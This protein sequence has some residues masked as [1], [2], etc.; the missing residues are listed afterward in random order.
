MSPLKFPPRRLLRLFT[1]RTDAN[2]PICSAQTFLFMHTCYNTWDFLYNGELP[3]SVIVISSLKLVYLIDHK[4]SLQA[5][6]KVSSLLLLSMIC[7][8]KKITKK[9]MLAC[10]YQASNRLSSAQKIHL[11]PT[12]TMKKIYIIQ[13]P[14]KQPDMFFLDIMQSVWYTKSQSQS[15]WGWS[16][17]HLHLHKHL[18]PKLLYSWK[19][20]RF[21][22]FFLFRTMSSQERK[23]CE[24]EMQHKQNLKY[25][26][27]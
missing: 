11:D 15:W 1:D 5:Q 21:F 8:Q 25:L 18:K 23:Q 20:K 3:V 22:F 7:F 27:V 13:E 2:K 24:M 14:A 9:G 10:L 4:S 16:G 6:W 17:C 26:T 12:A 19:T